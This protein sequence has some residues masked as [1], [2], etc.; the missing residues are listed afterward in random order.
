MTESRLEDIFE[1]ANFFPHSGKSA[2]E[3]IMFEA[4]GL[5]KN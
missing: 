5:E 3:F 4:D 2:N 1:E